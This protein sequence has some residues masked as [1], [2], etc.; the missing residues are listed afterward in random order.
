M[1]GWRALL[2]WAGENRP[3]LAIGIGVVLWLLV[4][5]GLTLAY[6]RRVFGD[7]LA[8]TES[9]AIC[10]AVAPFGVR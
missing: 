1:G 9:R 4:V 10:G 2:E 6:Q 8:A 7:C 3:I 5:A